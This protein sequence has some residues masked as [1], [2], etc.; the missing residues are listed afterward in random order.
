MNGQRI[1][2]PISGDDVSIGGDEPLDLTQHIRI[3]ADLCRVAIE[4]LLLVCLVKL[5]GE[6]DVKEHPDV[7]TGEN[8]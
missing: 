1:E 3:D 8:G 5:G 2:S 4:V 6:L 7:V